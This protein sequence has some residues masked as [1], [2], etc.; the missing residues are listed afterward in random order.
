MRLKP[1]MLALIA[2]VVLLA[3]CSIPGG[4]PVPTPTPIVP[5]HVPSPTS[6]VADVCPGTL[7]SNPNCYTPHA[8]RVAYGVEALTAQG[9]TGKGQTV[10]DIVSYGSP[11]LQQDMNV[12]DKQFGLPPITIQVVAPLG[13]VPFDPNNRE[14]SGWAG[15]TELDVEIMHAIAPGAGIVVMTSPV[16]ETEGTIGLPEF[17]KLE[18]Y[19][20][21]HHLGQIFSQSYVASE[22]TLADSAG[23]QLV[24]T[25]TDFYKQIT[26]QQGFTIV[27]GS[28]DNG[29]TDWANIAAT[30]LSPNPT[31]NFPAD[32]P[33]VTAVGGTALIHLSSCHP[34]CNEGSS[35]S[36]DEKAWSGSGGGMS[37]FFSEPDFQKTMPSSIQSQLK[38]Q[39]GLPDIAGDADPSTAMT[40][41][42]LGRW[43]QVGGTS[44]STPF[45]AAIVAIA[46]QVAG[47]SL[48]FINPA[49][50]KLGVSQNAQ[51]DFRDIISGSNTVKSGNI[52]VAGFQAAP[53]WDAVTGWGSPQ[54][55][56][57]IPDLIAA[58][59]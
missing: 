44:A 54:A 32:V 13:T 8:L 29:A 27:S 21:A 10:I 5:T 20:V 12:F 45:W 48:G 17:L 25:Y 58:M 41:Y 11:T 36:Y 43:T 24:K 34:Q 39:R 4:N 3:A 14:M 22:A 19:A 23:Q 37:T 42:I 40:D 47:H 33:W 52:Q 9:F 51:K 1:N 46:N 2:L 6:T 53:G 49:I 26:T 18:Q 31:V 56:Q 16:D 57:F 15:E 28:G 30:Q 38:G 50:Y 59:K 35:Y 55:S 7:S